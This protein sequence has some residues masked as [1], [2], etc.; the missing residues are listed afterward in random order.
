MHER[1]LARAG[2]PHDGDELARLHVERDAAQRVDGGLTLA[3]APR[4]IVRGDD[5]VARG[6]GPRLRLLLGRGHGPK[7]SAVPGSEK[8]C[9]DDAIRDDQRGF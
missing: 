1:R 8:P 2:R 5:D 3:V 6:R 7:V 4:Q 9:D